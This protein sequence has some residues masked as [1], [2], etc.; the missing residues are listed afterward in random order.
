[1]FKPATV[2]LLFFGCKLLYARAKKKGTRRRERH[3]GRERGGRG[4]E[5]ERENRAAGKD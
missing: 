4:T 3:I 5:R 1:M 2:A